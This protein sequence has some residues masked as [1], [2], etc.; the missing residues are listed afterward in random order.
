MAKEINF[1]GTGST[2]GGFKIESK[3]KTDELDQILAVIKSNFNTVKF[4]NKDVVQYIEN[5][6]A[7]Q[8]PSR[9]K[10]LVEAN[11]IVD[12]GG[13]PKFYALPHV[14]VSN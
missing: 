10:K 3:I 1:N 11:E 6:T 7:R 2:F 4:Q 14:D 13:N 8:V 5:L 12:L 9:L